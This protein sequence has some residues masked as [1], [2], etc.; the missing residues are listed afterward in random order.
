[1][2]RTMLVMPLFMIAIGSC[3][4][5]QP[6]LSASETRLCREQGGYLSRAPFGGA[7]CQFRY[8]DGGKACS[9]KRDC[10]GRCL[11]LGGDS[12]PALAPLSPATGTCEAERSTFGCYAE[13]L[14]GK[15]SAEG[16]ICVD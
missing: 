15:I 14:D 13:V 10:E 5:S 11:H 2:P 4:P 8:P 3:A 12:G 1:M 9:D 7:F 16:T 6:R